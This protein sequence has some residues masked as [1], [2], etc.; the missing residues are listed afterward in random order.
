MFVKDGVY[1]VGEHFQAAEYQSVVW[2]LVDS[3]E[4]ESG[5]PEVLITQNSPFF[6]IYTSFPAE[7]RWSR[8][9][10]TMFNAV[11]V[12][13]PWTRKEIHQA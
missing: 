1:Q 6:V 3:D 5:V 12:M 2:V 13:N 4:S 7:E 10:K 11:I 9:N 8:M